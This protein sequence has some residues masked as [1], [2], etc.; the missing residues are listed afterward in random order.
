MAAADISRPPETGL[1]DFLP[2]HNWAWFLV[3]GVIALLLGAAALFAPGVTLFA[4]ALLFAAFSFADGVAQLVAGIR[5]ATHKSQR[6]GSLIFGGIIGLLIG[7]LFLIWPFLSTLVYALM[8]AVL[9]AFWAIV[10]GALEI[11]AAVRLRRAIEG[12]WLLALSGGLS[13]LL[14][15]VLIAL[16]ASR[17]SVT[18]LSIGWLIAIYA[19]ASGIALIALAFRLRAKATG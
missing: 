3:R 4:F 15:F 10:T 18:V 9:I 8:A 12:E 5:G 2:R 7:V 13:V 16:V 19:F 11:A 1:G 14:G 6:Y 17:P